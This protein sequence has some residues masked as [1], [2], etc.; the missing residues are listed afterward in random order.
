MM[1]LSKIPL[2]GSLNPA[3]SGCIDLETRLERMSGKL[4][5]PTAALR[6]LDEKSSCEV[7]SI[8]SSP[9]VMFSLRYSSSSFT[10][11]ASMDSN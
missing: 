7:K 3:P 5:P 4:I 8:S 10:G 9:K 6:P 11:T 2:L 1:E